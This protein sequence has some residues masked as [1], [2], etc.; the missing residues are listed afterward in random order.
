VVTT[1]AEK[2]DALARIVESFDRL[3][4]ALATREQQLGE[5]LDALRGSIEGLVAGL[6]DLSREGLS[7]V[8]E[9][10]QQLR[11]DIQTLTDAA[12]V[13]DANLSSVSQL[14][15]AG[16]LLGK[17]MATCGV[18]GAQAGEG[19]PARIAEST[20][21][22]S[23]L[24]LLEAPG[25]PAGDGGPGWPERAGGWVQDGARTLLGAGA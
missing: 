3:T 6:A 1:F 2:D 5:V 8:A 7:L 18:A 9:H 15:D 10:D 17:V 20:P 13:I 16:G 25:A 22:G 4:R 19:V 12:A 11:T 24:A 21:I 14:L 23:L